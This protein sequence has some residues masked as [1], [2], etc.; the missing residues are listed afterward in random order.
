MLKP[1]TETSTLPYISRHSRKETSKMSLS[2]YPTARV[3][4]QPV[5]G[6]T[7]EQYKQLH[8]TEQLQ[9]RPLREQKRWQNNKDVD[10]DNYIDNFDDNEIL[11]REEIQ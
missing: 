6:L 11:D 4:Y 7:D 9:L 3:H 10:Y 1:F 5:N 8:W 2:A